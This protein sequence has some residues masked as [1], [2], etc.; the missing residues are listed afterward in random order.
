MRWLGGV[1]WVGTVFGC[2][3][4][5]TQKQITDMIFCATDID[6]AFPA[7]ALCNQATMQSIQH[8]T[9]CSSCAALPAQRGKAVRPPALGAL[10]H[11]SRDY[12]ELIR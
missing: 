6:Q 9:P 1:G 8:A 3:S 10:R 4:V 2:P 7:F 12:A 11:S 5:C